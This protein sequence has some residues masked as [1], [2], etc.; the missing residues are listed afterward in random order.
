[1]SDFPP[2]QLY[3]YEPDLEK[4]DAVAYAFSDKDAEPKQFPFTFPEL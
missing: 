3:K 2:H 1:M 4:A